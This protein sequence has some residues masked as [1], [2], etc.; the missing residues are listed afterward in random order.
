L[1]LGVPPT[2]LPFNPPFG[3]QPLLDDAATNYSIFCHE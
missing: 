2:P 3:N 1:G